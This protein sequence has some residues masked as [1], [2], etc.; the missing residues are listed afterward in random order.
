MNE[1]IK[2]LI[3]R[4]SVRRFKPEQIKDE[5]LEMILEA[6]KY[7]ASGKN[8]QPTHMVVIRDKEIL[9]KLSDMNKEFLGKPEMPD[10]FFGAPTVILVL[11][12]RK[13][14]NYLYDGSLVMGNLM[15]AAHSLGIGSCW[16]NR[17]KE[18]FNTEY[19]K[20]LLKEWGLDGDY[21][22]IGHC[23]LGYVDGDYPKAAPR[24]ADFVTY[25]G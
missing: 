12:D 14:S 9:K 4:R 1:T 11:A 22:G 7:A 10:A 21:E 6:G 18:E 20:S 24:K 25:I 2:N 19:G 23:I 3:E 16:I 8:M 15:N 13:S 5:E 17:A